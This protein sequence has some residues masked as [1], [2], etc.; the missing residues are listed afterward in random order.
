MMSFVGDGMTLA[1]LTGKEIG[2]PGVSI[3]EELSED[4]IEDTCLEIKE[5]PL[6]GDEGR[7]DVCN[8]NIRHECHFYYDLHDLKHELHAKDSS[9]LVHNCNDM[10]KV[11]FRAKDCGKTYSSDGVQVMYEERQKEDAQLKVESKRKCFACEV[12][13]KELSQKSHISIHMRVHTEEKPYNCEICNNTF[14]RKNN[15]VRHMRIHAS[16]K[17]YSCEICNKAFSERSHLVKHTRVHTKEKPYNCKICNSA[18]SRKNNLVRHMRTHTKEKP[19]SCEICNKAFSERGHQVAAL[20]YTPRRSH[21]VVKFI[22]ANQMRVH[23][24]YLFG[25]TCVTD[26]GSQQLLLVIAFK[27]AAPLPL[28]MVNGSCWP[29]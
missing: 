5:E 7:N 12:C 6:D 9:N 18:Y 17:P 19:Y 26:Q 14:S 28:N 2:G 13:G 25:Q 1:L 23:E 22:M 29:F 11:S 27:E 4:V 8:V 21:T 24:K 3:K 10:S 20:E 15:L 16:K